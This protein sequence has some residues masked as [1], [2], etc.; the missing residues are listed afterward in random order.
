MKSF[1]TGRVL[2]LLLVLVVIFTAFAAMAANVYAM[3]GQTRDLGT[4]I[5][6]FATR[7][8]RMP[9]SID[10]LVRAGYAQPAGQAGLYQLLSAP[11]GEPLGQA[12]PVDR[13]EVAWGV[14]PEQLLER[15]KGVF[16]RDAPDKRVLLVRHTAPPWAVRVLRGRMA[17]AF[18]VELYRQLSGQPS[19]QS[20]PAANSR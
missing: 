5:A 16:W 2:V 3:G 9:A 17:M 12:V 7:Y 4:A 6:L 18:P 20:Q 8:D 13:F 11:Q 19:S 10:E 15:D 14:Q 1:P